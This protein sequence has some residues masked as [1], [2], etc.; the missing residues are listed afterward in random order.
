MIN[1]NVINKKT[2]RAIQLETLEVLK[3]ALEKSF[4]PFGSNSII[5]KENGL[6]RYTKD[7]H[8]ILSAIQFLGPIERSVA[9]DIVEET[10]TQA[11][12]VGDS[13][14]S[15]TI[16]SYLIFKR[17][18]EFEE[19][20]PEIPPA[21][22][23]KT[24]KGVVEEIK[25]LITE[26]GRPA[27]IE[28]MYNI[29]LIS[30]NG[31]ED[32]A[33]EVYHIY[34]RFGLDVYVDV[35]ASMNGTTY[36]KEINGMTIDC[37]YLDT[38]FVNTENNSCEIRNPYIYAFSDPIDTIEMA[39]IFDAII[40]KNIIGPLNEYSNIMNGDD[41]EAKRNADLNY[42]PTVIFAPKFSRDLSATIDGIMK[43]LAQAKAVAK[44]P[45]CII[46]NI[47]KCDHNQY[48]LISTFCGCNTI[49]K[50]IDPE[51][52]QKDIDDKKAIDYKNPYETI[53]NMAGHAD[54][55][56]SDNCKTTVVRPCGI[57]DENGNYSELYNT[58]ISYYESQI[59]KLSIEGNNTTE[60]YEVKKLLNS[61]KGN[62]VE[63]YIGGVTVAD[64]D[65][66]RDLMED[67]ILN[68]RSA[69]RTGVGYGANFEG[70]AAS[71]KLINK[72]EVDD[73]IHYEISKI[74]AD[75]YKEIMTI[76]YGTVF[77]NEG[78]L[79]DV[80][81]QS[82]EKGQPF[83]L[84]TK[85]FDGKVLSSIDTDVWALD[86]ISKIVTIMATSNQFILP[87]VNVNNY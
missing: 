42:I 74:I 32:L 17:L 11:I 39:N 47:E 50:Y 46:T 7:G 67:A 14:T 76:L 4:G 5:Y 66:I 44:P 15:V 73:V 12:K 29:A 1:S 26:N 71:R 87:T 48:D 77:K 10:R 81:E 36:L 65:Q 9:S 54:M 55:I 85:S 25:K 84:R 35:K 51:L 41:E 79:N 20:H 3:T 86:T 49:H 59:Q 83:N 19:S 57:Y 6:P 72:N 45:L 43:Q 75:S 69:A 70:A 64:R 78:S 27:T 34:D 16:L 22:I 58:R 38:S 8:T 56:I 30:T 53:D 21:D 62:M 33:K 28:D 80:L 24:F 61:L 40:Y 31:D 68:C 2:L 82:F 63:A 23:V 60:I 18:V 13:T 52:Q 37:G